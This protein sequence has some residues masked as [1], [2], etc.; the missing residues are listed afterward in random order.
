MIVRFTTTYAIGGYHHWWCEF[1]SGSGRS[2]Q[3]Y[4]IKFA[5]GR[6]FS[7]GPPVSPTNKT[8]RHDVDE[9]FLKVVLNTIKQT[10][11]QTNCY[12]FLLLPFH[13]WLWS[14]QSLVCLFSIF[15]YWQH[16]SVSNT[17]FDIFTLYRYMFCAFQE[18]IIYRTIMSMT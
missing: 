8:D 12:L 5:T 18:S 9:I 15:R 17:S 1:E 7:P 11:K 2:V 16:I 6:W 13:L 10:Y 4:V 3:H 14:R